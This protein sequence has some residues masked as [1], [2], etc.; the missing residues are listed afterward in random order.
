MPHGRVLV[1]F[2]IK[3]AWIP[4]TYY[5][6][7]PEYFGASLYVGNHF[8]SLMITLLVELQLGDYVLCPMD[9]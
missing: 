1:G 7:L 6:E 4:F 8:F 5:D 9:E 3:R 2:K